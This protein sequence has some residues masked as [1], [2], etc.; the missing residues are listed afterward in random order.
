MACFQPHSGTTGLDSPTPELSARPVPMGSV[1]DPDEDIVW[2]TLSP[3]EK[4]SFSNPTG[5]L[6]EPHKCLFFQGPVKKRL[7]LYNSWKSP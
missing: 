4:S 6:L 3:L 7:R 2:G 5:H 1:R